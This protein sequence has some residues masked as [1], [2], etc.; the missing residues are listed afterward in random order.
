MKW[1]IKRVLRITP[2][3]LPISKASNI[4]IDRCIYLL[5]S[6]SWWNR[7]LECYQI[8]FKVLIRIKQELYN[9]SFLIWE[10]QVRILMYLVLTTILHITDSNWWHVLTYQNQGLQRN[11]SAWIFRRKWLKYIY[12][13]LWEENRGL[14]NY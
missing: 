3:L 10:V 2:R 12:T 9:E 14:E 4:H 5:S 11:R 8:Y 1:A 7:P 6:L 13:A